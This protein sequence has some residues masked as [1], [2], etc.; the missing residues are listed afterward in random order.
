MFELHF[1]TIKGDYKN[2]FGRGALGMM[3]L[4][5]P[6]YGNFS[7]MVLSFSFSLSLPFHTSTNR[8]KLYQYLPQ[9]LSVRIK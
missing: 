4:R 9:K 8:Y 5:A 1:T 6:L 2:L 7:C 3:G